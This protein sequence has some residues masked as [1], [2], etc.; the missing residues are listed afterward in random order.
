[1]E[2]EEE[3]D[4]YSRDEEV[5]GYERSNGER[6]DTMRRRGR[7]GNEDGRR[8][9]RKRR[10]EEEE[11]GRMR[12]RVRERRCRRRRMRKVINAVTWM[13]TD[14]SGWSVRR[15]GGELGEQEAVH[16]AA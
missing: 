5:V 2:E 9:W 7:E 14:K 16:T 1:M 13:R 6:R 12:R 10:A 11:D 3:M 4:E 8:R 15:C